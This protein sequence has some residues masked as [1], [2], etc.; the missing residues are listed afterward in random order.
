[1]N[2]VRNR[3]ALLFFVITA[4]AVGFIYLYVVPQLRSSLT[5]EKL[6]N[7]E[8]LGTEQ[9]ARLAAAM[10]DGISQPDL[11][12]LIRDIDQRTGSRVTVLGVRAGEAGPELAFVVGDSALERTAL[13]PAY[14]AAAAAAAT[15]PVATAV[16]RVG[17]E[18]IG[19]TAIAL[20]DEG[21]PRWVA[22]LSDSLD[23][24][25]DNVALIRRQ[26]LIAGAIALLAALAAG[27]FVAGAH[28]RRLRRLEQAAEKVADGDFSTVIPIGSNDEVGQLAVSFNEMQKRLARLDSARKEFIANASHELRTPIFS[29]GGFVELLQ[30]EDPD[31][32]AREEFVRTMRG[33][34]A[35]LTKL[36]ADLLDLSKLDAD[37]IEIRAETV[38]LGELLRRVVA[39]FGPAADGHGS[40]I[41]V[42]DQRVRAL[43]DP[44]RTAQIIRILIDN[45]LTH[46]PEGTAISVT[47]QL[48]DGAASLVVRDRGPGIDA[49]ARERVFERFYTGDEVGGSGLGLAIARELALRM[50]GQLDLRSRHGRTE[51]ELRLPAAVAAESRA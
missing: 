31:P 3:L 41:E 14:P 16:E 33:Q 35:R 1:M 18:R 39:E 46:T 32:A 10:R 51:F 6:R 9:S 36:T 28:A 26:I 22:V 38:D 42:I 4:A 43:A 11:R 50:E 2:S 21:E 17:G 20:Y 47:A 15:G 29:L 37:A 7:L 8:S 34:V 24:V 12:R 45:A 25:D 23:E 30:D 27:W 44:D 13:V 19:E 49:R 5:A 40:R 48:Q